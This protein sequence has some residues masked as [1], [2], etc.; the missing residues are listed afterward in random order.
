MLVQNWGRIGQATWP[1][2][3]LSDGR[4]R[5]FCTVRTVR[6]FARSTKTCIFGKQRQVFQM[7]IATN[8]DRHDEIMDHSRCVS[9]KRDDKHSLPW[10]LARR[11]TLL[12]MKPSQE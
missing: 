10:D 7:R 9:K 3:P 5:E 1:L 11:S 4:S 6:A 12:V 2:D 8:I